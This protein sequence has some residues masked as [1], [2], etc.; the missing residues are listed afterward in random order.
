MS[1]EAATRAVAL[2]ERL[3]VL[4]HDCRILVPQ[5]EAPSTE[6]EPVNAQ[7]ERLLSHS[8]IGSRI[9]FLSGRAEAP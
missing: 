5:L 8:V 1:D 4:L 7:A 3:F 6:A 2:L 9:P